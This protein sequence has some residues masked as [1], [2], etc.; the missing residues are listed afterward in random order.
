M[1]PRSNMETIPFPL[2]RTALRPGRGANRERIDGNR[3]V[4]GKM[5]TFSSSS[6]PWYQEAA[7]TPTTPALPMH[8]ADTPTTVAFFRSPQC[9]EQLRHIPTLLS[10]CRI[11]HPYTNHFL[12]DF[13][14][15]E[16][17]SPHV[18]CPFPRIVPGTTRRL[19]QR[20]RRRWQFIKRHKPQPTWQTFHQK[21]LRHTT[22]HLR[23]EFHDPGGSTSHFTVFRSSKD[24]QV[25]EQSERYV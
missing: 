13:R 22:S 2:C 20:C 7:G 11:C 10:K 17:R 12:R 24:L 8:D 3:Q 19:S 9:A 4:S 23:Y 25:D 1:K 14:S 15:S 16:R 6:K 5:A 18:F 21:L